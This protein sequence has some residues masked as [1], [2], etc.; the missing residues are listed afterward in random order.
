MIGTEY[1]YGKTIMIITPKEHEA[2]LKQKGP[3]YKPYGLFAIEEKDGSWT[4][5]KNSRGQAQTES[6]PN[7]RLAMRYLADG[8][9]DE[10]EYHRDDMMRIRRKTMRA[11]R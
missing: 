5:I 10:E 8:S 7:K 4:V 9:F 6:L 1:H 2:F 3:Y 11:K